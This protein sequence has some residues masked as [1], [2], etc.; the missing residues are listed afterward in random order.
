MEIDKIFYEVLIAPKF[1]TEALKI[2][3]K[4]IKE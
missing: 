3:K 1:T 4:K 2:L